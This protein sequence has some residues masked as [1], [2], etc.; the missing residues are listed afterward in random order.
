ML[1]VGVHSQKVFLHANCDLGTNWMKRKISG[2]SSSEMDIIQDG[3]KF[4]ARI[5]NNETRFTVGDDFDETQKHGVV[6]KAI[7]ILLLHGIGSFGFNCAI[8]MRFS[9]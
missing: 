2:A 1:S 6:M 9:N 4:V 8:R 7:I 3:D 5:R